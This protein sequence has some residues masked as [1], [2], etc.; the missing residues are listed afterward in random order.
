[1]AKPKSFFNPNAPDIVLRSL[2]MKYDIDGN[3]KLDRNELTS[4]LKDDLGLTDSQVEAYYLLLDKDG[5]AKISFD[6]LVSWLKSG[7]RFKNIQD[8][9]RY[10]RLQKAVKMFKKYDT[11]G[12][13]SL[14]REE[15]KKLFCD[16]GGKAKK[17][18]AAF[19]SMDEDGNGKIAF[20]EFL[21]WLNW[22][23]ME[24]F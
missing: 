17:L 8:K 12:S 15:F 16:C 14:D 13:H 10:H 7:E 1:M 2:Y 20:Q 23:P 6:E 9:T 3:G 18:D 22:I 19:A 4:L 11:D 24:E 21:K 5:D